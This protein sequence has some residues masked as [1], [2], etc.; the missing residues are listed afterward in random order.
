MPC[1]GFK[2]GNINKVICLWPMVVIQDIFDGF[3][4]LKGIVNKA[5][6]KRAILIKIFSARYSPSVLKTQGIN[7]ISRWCIVDIY[8]ADIHV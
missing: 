4:V 1:L 5:V 6:R 8:M 2:I 7:V 3:R